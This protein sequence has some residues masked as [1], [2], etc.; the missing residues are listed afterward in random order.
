[1]DLELKKNISEQLALLSQQQER[2]DKACKGVVVL[3]EGMG[4]TGKASVINKMISVI[5]PKYYNVEILNTCEDDERVPLLTKYFSKLPEYGGFTFFDSGWYTEVARKAV[6]DKNFDFE[7][8]IQDIRYLEKSILDNGYVLVK[9]YLCIDKKE[10]SRRIK[11]LLSNE[12]TAWKISD[13][14]IWEHK[15]FNKLLKY[16]E[17]LIDSTT[18]TLILESSTDKD[19]KKLTLYQ[20]LKNTNDIIDSCIEMKEAIAKLPELNC[21]E[22]DYIH[23]VEI[24]SVDDTN[25]KETL[26]NLQKKLSKLQDKMYKKGIATVITFEGLDAAGKGGAIKRLTKRLDPRSYKI[27]PI[28]APTKEE[29]NRHFLYRFWNKIPKSGH[30]AIFDRTWYGRVLVERIEGFCSY[31]DYVKAYEE[32]KEFESYLSNN[33]VLLIKFWIDIDKE[34]Q[35]NRFNARKTNPE[36]AW[37]LTDEDWRNREKWDEYEQAAKDMFVYTGTENACWHIVNGNNKK[38]AR[39]AV[40]NTVISEMEKMINI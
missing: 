7:Q 30:V 2:L 10:Q 39:I 24:P 34:E 32:I 23:R 17:E 8:A 1:M 31:N 4:E 33:N 6:L 13:I 18:T 5:D 38:Q 21:T 37:K 22:V 27:H 9:M 40:L 35:L 25:Y 15:H 28:A 14:D 20:A 19:K 16:Y 11:K 29:K 26:E 36:K 12:D 3:V